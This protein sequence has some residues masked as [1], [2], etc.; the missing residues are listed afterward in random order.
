MNLNPSAGPKDGVQGA[1]WREVAGWTEIWWKVI[2]G[3]KR[4]VFSGLCKTGW[5]LWLS[6]GHKFRQRCGGSMFWLSW[7]VHGL[8]WSDL[9][10]IQLQVPE[11]ATWARV[12]VK[13]L[14]HVRP[15][16]TPWTAAY[17]V[18][19]SLTISQS[20]P[21]FMSIASVIPSSHLIFS[22]PLP[23]RSSIFPII[24]DFPVIWLFARC[25]QNTGASASTSV[26]P[27]SIQG[28]FPLRLT[29][30]IPY[31]PRDSQESSPIP[32]IERISS[33]LC[34]LYGPVLRTILNY[35]KKHSLDYTDLCRQ[36]NVFA[37]YH[38]V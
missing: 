31:C 3:K 21:K 34:L 2:G 36:S 38:T 1:L 33:V 16:V 26:L 23:L 6:I 11:K 20:L 24:R 8:N 37:F 4:E 15:F 17:Q 9:G 13:L 22:C 18:A 10:K 14:R 30:L 35:W 19:L 25:D 28:W 32:Q 12:V 29:S 7:M 27:V 5:A